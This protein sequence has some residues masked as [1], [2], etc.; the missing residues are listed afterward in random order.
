MRGRKKI[1]FH[2]EKKYISTSKFAFGPKNWLFDKQSEKKELR[3]HTPLPPSRSLELEIH[4][5]PP[6]LPSVRERN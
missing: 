5:T 4:L 2:K 1:R 3:F 6:P